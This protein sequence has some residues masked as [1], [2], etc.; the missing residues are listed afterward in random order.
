MKSAT[1][2]IHVLL[3]DDEPDFA[4]V[5]A[6]FLEREVER[7]E[8][9]VETGAGE[10]VAVLSEEP[11]DCVVSDFDMREIDGLEFL[12]TV[13]SEYDDLPFIL[14]TGRGSEDVASEAISAGVTDYLQ[15]Q[16]GTDDYK[17]LANRIVDAVSQVRTEQ[18]LGETE[19]WL[20]MILDATKTGIWEWN[21]ETNDLA[22]NEAME[23]SIGL[24]P[25]T[26]E[27][28][29]DAFERRVHPVDMPRVES[30]VARAIEDDELF[31]LEFR[32]LHEDGRIIWTNGRGRIIRDER[33]GDRMVGIHHD[34][35]ERKRR[36][37]E[38]AEDVAAALDRALEALED[39]LFVIGPDGDLRR[40]NDQ[41]L[42]VTGRGADDLAGIRAAELFPEAERDRV[43]SAFET[44]LAS[45]HATVESHV[46]AASGERLPREFTCARL[47]DSAGE[48][49]SLV[50]VVR[51]VTG[52]GPDAVEVESPTG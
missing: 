27:G 35:T 15:K 5:S 3:V 13:R 19:R 18:R 41:A 28:T 31:Q 26:F 1:G 44:A 34:I 51:P 7:I 39:P 43:T 12:R 52:T 21:M 8:C 46:H 22:W 14:Y 45:G 48:P 17:L 37:R 47:V 33:E 25:G 42:E 20:E 2:P 11:I 40:W 49:T 9:H 4:E 38:R 30:A 50:V 32:K 36:E 10:G 6:I 29:Y 16:A 24:E 23:R